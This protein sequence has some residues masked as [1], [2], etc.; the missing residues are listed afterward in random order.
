MDDLMNPNKISNKKKFKVKF[1]LQ[2][3][4]MLVT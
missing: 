3:I 1:S 2:R 4:F